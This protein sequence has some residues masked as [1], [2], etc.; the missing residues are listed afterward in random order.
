MAKSKLS[1]VFGKGK[2]GG[3][4]PPGPD[5]LALIIGEEPDG[6]EE[7]DPEFEDNIVEAFPDLEGS[8]DRIAA[9]RRAIQAVM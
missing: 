4:S 9:L 2:G 6:D 3:K 7:M 1:D 8:P 5:G